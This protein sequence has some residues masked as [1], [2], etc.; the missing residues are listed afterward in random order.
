MA[1][2]NESN[3]VKFVCFVYTQTRDTKE[4]E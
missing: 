3:A 4:L 2:L 1:D